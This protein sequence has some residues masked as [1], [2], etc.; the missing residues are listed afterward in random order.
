MEPIQTRTSAKKE[1][2]ILHEC[3][4][5]KEKK[6]NMAANDDNLEL[7]MHVTQKGNMNETITSHE[8]KHHHKRRS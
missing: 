3:T 8:K 5:C 2:Q 1:W 4:L 7:L 6:W